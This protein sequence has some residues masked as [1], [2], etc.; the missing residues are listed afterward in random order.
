MRPV[1]DAPAFLSKA[2][3]QNSPGQ[4]TSYQQERAFCTVGEE[5]RWPLVFNSG[6]LIRN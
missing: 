2:K 3:V 6:D 1:V 5:S 4:K